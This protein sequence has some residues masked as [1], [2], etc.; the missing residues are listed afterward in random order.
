MKASPEIAR[1]LNTLSEFL[2]LEDLPTLS[3]PALKAACGSEAVDLV[4]L[5][6]NAV[7]ATAERAF[8]AVEEGLAGRLVISGGVGHST[9]FLR[10]AV[11]RHPRYRGIATRGLS[12]AE[13]LARV[14]LDHFGLEQGRLVLETTSANCG[15]NAS[16]T[17]LALDRLGLA[18]RVVVLVQDPTLQRRSDASFRQSFLDRPETRLLNHPTFVPRL[19]PSAGGL[20][21]QHPDAEGLWPLER[22]LALVMGEIP[23]LRDDERG[24]G[25]RGRGFIPHVEVPPAV[26]AAHARLE[27]ALGPVG[28]V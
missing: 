4:V 20:A 24:Y 2:A 18:P 25:P 11:A 10:D 6:A 21:F 17:R 12:E 7:L 15:E 26:L 8:R 5:L 28:R 22:F 13:I 1:D 27:A 14:A 9:P 23:R 19:A 16:R 3:A